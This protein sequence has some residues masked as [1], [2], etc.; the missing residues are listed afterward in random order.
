MKVHLT[1]FLICAAIG[2]LTRTNKNRS[3]SADIQSLTVAQIFKK[4]VFFIS[5]RLT[6]YDVVVKEARIDLPVLTVDRM[7]GQ[8]NE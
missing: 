2:R 4:T 6:V 8:V 5:F 3:T 7:N 1:L